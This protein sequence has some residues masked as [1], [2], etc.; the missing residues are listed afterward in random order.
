MT[1][2]ATPSDPVA[3]VWE[4]ARAGDLRGG[5]VAAR[6]QLSR[7]GG[8]ATARERVE[9]HLAAACCAMRQGHHA[10]ALR[11]L[12]LAEL[13]AKPAEPALGSRIDVWRAELAYC[14]RR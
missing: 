10:D 1:L 7:S 4:L 14:Q 6:E 13:T 11:D 3:R 5:A 2:Q 8:K 12:D 9:L